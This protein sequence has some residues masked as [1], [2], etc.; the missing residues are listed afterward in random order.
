MSLPD[1]TETF[2]Q[3]AR[4][5]LEQPREA[6]GRREAV[7]VRVVVRE[8]ERPPPSAGEREQGA[9]PLVGLAEPVQASGSRRVLRAVARAAGGRGPLFARATPSVCEPDDDLT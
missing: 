9:Q 4:E 7:R 8:H 1:P 3:E 2:R 5:L 6:D